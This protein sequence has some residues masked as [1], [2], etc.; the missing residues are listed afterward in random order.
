MAA[1][2]VGGALLSAFLQ[3][4]FDRLASPQVLDFFRG[5]K[6]DEKLLSK[7]HITL[8]SINSLADDAEQK[9]FRDPYVK[10]WLLAVNDAV[11]DS[12]VLLDSIDYELI[13]C[14]VE[15]ESAPQSLTSK[16]SNFFDS[17]FRSFNKKINSGM[18]EVTEKLEYLAKQKGAL[19]LKKY[20]YS[21]DGPDSKVP[22]KLPSSSL[23]VESVI[24]G[25]D[26]DKE[27]IFNWLTSE[28]DNHN[29]LSILSI[30]DMGGLGKTT[31]A[32]H[33]YNDPKIDDAKF[34]IKAWVCVSD[35]FDV[36]TVTKTI[37]ES[38]TDKK[39]DSG[40]L[41]MVHK[42]LKEKLSVKKFLLV[43]DDVWNEKREEWE[44]VQTPLNYGAPGSR[45]LVTTRAEKVASNMRSKV[46]HLKQLEKDECWKVFKKHALKDD[47]LELND[48]KK[49]IG[50]SIVENAKDYLSL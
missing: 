18:R 20:S 8:H 23:V 36:L 29:H 28:T 15:A 42:N 5:R 17:T 12:E 7:L 44:V 27:I 47:D 50:R 16:V 49:K 24:Y 19:G 31:L 26:A 22:Q 13:K 9:Q 30:V 33:V 37:L 14:N 4:A 32:Q 40:N 2:L 39:D 45:I 34:D 25:R 43:L 48:E 6:L 10:A 35:H 41:N 3:V 46:H 21:G 1:E 11:F 38:I